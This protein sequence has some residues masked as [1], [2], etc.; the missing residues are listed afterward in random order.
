MVTGG[1]G[2]IGWELCRQIALFSPGR[3][4]I[5]DQNESGIYEAEMSLL[6]KYPDLKVTIV[7]GHIQNKRQMESIFKKYDFQVVFYDHTRGRQSD[8]SSRCP[9]RGR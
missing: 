1:S 4:I 2:S 8:P 3:L 7:P 9:R 6:S 5:V